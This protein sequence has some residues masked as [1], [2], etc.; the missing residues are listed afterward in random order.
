MRAWQ[1]GTLRK[2]LG[3]L[4]IVWACGT[5]GSAH[6]QLVIGDQHAFSAA[7]PHPYGAGTAPGQLVWTQSIV[8]PGATGMWVHLATIDLAPGDWAVVRDA[9][10]TQ[11]ETL[12]GLGRQDLG[13]FWSVRVPG[14]TAVVEIWSQ[15]ST[16][17]FGITIDAYASAFDPVTTE[18]ICG[19]NDLEDVIC[20]AAAEAAAVAESA[21]VCRVTVF[22]DD[23]RVFSCTGFR[24]ACTCDV[25]LAADCID[26]V[27]EARAA[28]FQFAADGP[29]CRQP[30]TACSGEGS[31][32]G[33]LSGASLLIGP[34]PERHHALVGNLCFG[35]DSGPNPGMRLSR[36]AP[37]PGARIY[38]PQHARGCFKQFGMLDDGSVS[39]NCELRSTA[40]LDR[41]NRSGDDTSLSFECDT[42]AGSLGAPVVAHDTHQ[43][44]GLH[45]CIL[46]VG[47]CTNTAVPIIR[48]LPELAP[49]IYPA[50]VTGVRVA[51]SPSASGAVDVNVLWSPVPGA[52]DYHLYEG[53]L[54]DPST[55]SYLPGTYDHMADIAAIPPA[56]ACTTLGASS[57]VLAN[58]GGWSDG[59]DDVYFVVVAVSCRGDEGSYGVAPVLG[60]ANPP[61]PIPAGWGCP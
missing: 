51:K 60:L 25:L 24:V 1:F 58:R 33:T 52:A 26:T 59:S 8:H 31:A 38:V 40:V 46:S 6:A 21:A 47:L 42:D 18:S 23:G 27:T 28:L 45:H 36:D 22:E 35:P 17:G 32:G 19:A 13:T 2:L 43:V 34:A 4:T 53:H 57:A 30:P 39:G 11:P 55:A 15:S 50:E 44:I 61:Q 14:D 56:G 37:M 49:F 12:T 48:I 20:Q 9:A 7:S 54:F 16:P 41:C 3:I 29:A 5:A 10:G